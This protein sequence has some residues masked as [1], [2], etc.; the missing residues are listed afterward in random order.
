MTKH[1]G[2]SEI[3]T[4]AKQYHLR[5]L[6]RM[7]CIM[8]SPYLINGWASSLRI[9]DAFCGDGENVVGGKVIDGSPV[10]IVNGIIE[11]HQSCKSLRTVDHLIKCNFS[12]IRD[13]AISGLGPK[14]FDKF[15]FKSDLFSHNTWESKVICERLTATNA[16]SDDIKYLQDNPKARL[17]LVIDTNGPSDIPFF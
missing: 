17:L 14:M 16:L 6:V 13:D 9:R 10:S 11:A 4:P 3:A 8:L 2:R 12:D 15:N 1:Q 5:S 7:R